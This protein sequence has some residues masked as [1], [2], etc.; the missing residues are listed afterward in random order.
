MEA[1]AEAKRWKSVVFFFFYFKRARR[2]SELVSQLTKNV[3]LESAQ[4]MKD[5][6]LNYKHPRRARIQLL[7]QK[8]LTDTRIMA[9]RKRVEQLRIAE[10]FQP[11]R[12]VKVA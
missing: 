9:E 2:D 4:N 7:K 3:C 1:W 10:H 6:K 8:S 11:V 12:L 5:T